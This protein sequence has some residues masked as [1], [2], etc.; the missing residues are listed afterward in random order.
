[1]LSIIE[2]AGLMCIPLPSPVEEAVELLRQKSGEGKHE[3]DEEE[4]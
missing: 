4:K 1:M 3:H 2:K